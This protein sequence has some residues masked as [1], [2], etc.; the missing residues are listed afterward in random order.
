M[1]AGDYPLLP[2]C[3]LALSPPPLP[4]LK[5]KLS[6]HAS[7]VSCKHHFCLHTNFWF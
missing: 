1:Q 2:L 3:F 5:L 6:P 4:E 7:P